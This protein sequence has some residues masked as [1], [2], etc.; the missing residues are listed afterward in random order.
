MR[1]VS[2]GP[3]IIKLMMGPELEFRLVFCNFW[4]K[5]T[6]WPGFYDYLERFFGNGD[7]I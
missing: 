2:F 6:V 1:T 3:R 5:R 4:L 7:L